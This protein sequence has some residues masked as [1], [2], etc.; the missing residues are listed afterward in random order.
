MWTVVLASLSSFIDQFSNVV[1]KKIENDK[2]KSTNLWALALVSWLGSSIVIWIVFIA[3]GDFAFNWGA[4]GWFVPRI[5]LEMF[6]IYVTMKAL[7]KADLSFFSFG[8]VFSII[9]VMFLEAR[10]LG[11]TLRVGQYG[12]VFLVVFS[13]FIFLS[14]SIKRTKGWFWVMLSSLNGGLLFVITK[15]QFSYNNAFTNE[16]ILRLVLVLLMMLLVWGRRK[17]LSW[18]AKAWLLL[19]FRSVVGVLNLLALSLGAATIYSTVDRGGSVLSG[20]VLGNRFFK[21]K[22]LLEKLGVGFGIILGIICLSML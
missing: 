20:V 1:I 13:I 7:E 17:S 11:I 2:K 21:E 3:R 9:I 16:S 8:R 15:L 10:F 6:Q 5:V 12:G 22:S 4:W 18:N 14:R 19:P